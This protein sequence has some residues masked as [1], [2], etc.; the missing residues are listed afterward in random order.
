MDIQ[1][2]I[3][4]TLFMIFSCLLAR[5]AETS[6]YNVIWV[7][8]TYIF[9]VLFWSIRYQIG[10]DYGGYMH[11]FLMVR[12]GSPTMLEPAYYLINK[13]FS[14]SSIGYVGVFAVMSAL[15]YYFLFKTLIKERILTYGIF[16]SLAFQLQFMAANQIRQSFVLIAFLCI[17]HL[18]EE[19]KIWQYTWWSLLLATFH[20]SS[21]FLTAAILFR[22][23]RFPR[24]IWFLLIVVTYAAYLAGVFRTIGTKLMQLLPFY[25]RYQDST[26]MEAEQT[27]FS[28]VMLFWIIIALYLLLYE[29][30][31][32]RPVLFNIYMCSCILYCAFFE[33]H[34][35]TRVV[36]YF[37]YL[38]IILASVLCKN[39]QRDGMILIAISI[40]GY[41]LLCLKV[42]NLHGIQP[43]Q[44]IFQEKIK[45]L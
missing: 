31:I 30:T 32:N 11:G 38:N 4:Y 41:L 3:I 8:A 17:V 23:I 1:S 26:R 27:G 13:L 28:I 16:F 29:K 6:G 40:I 22:K 43:Y 12:Y 37:T 24:T 36:T 39:K 33:Y 7:F 45:R 15:C 44:T 35:I 25:D 18:L 10:Y 19:K 34:L 21:I 42:P 9:I 5:K 20:I 14:G 2:T